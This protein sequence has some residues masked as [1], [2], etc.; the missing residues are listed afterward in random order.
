MTVI[1]YV[2]ILFLQYTDSTCLCVH[3]NF[4]STMTVTV[5]VFI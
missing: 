5:Y 3:L 2:F 1:F 4:F